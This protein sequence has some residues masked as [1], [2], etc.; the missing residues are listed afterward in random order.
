MKENFNT[1]EIDNNTRNKIRSKIRNEIK[2]NSDITLKS[3]T[4]SGAEL[5]FKK[6]TFSLLI[7]ITL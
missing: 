1:N 3:L 6:D 4:I 2:K 7:F 5:D